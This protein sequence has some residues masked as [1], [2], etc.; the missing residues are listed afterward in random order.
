MQQLLEITFN[1]IFSLYQNTNILQI[2]I[3]K[4]KEYQK[5]LKIIDLCETAI[6]DKIENINDNDTAEKI[7]EIKTYCMLELQHKHC[8]ARMYKNIINEERNYE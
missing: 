1:Q 4:E 6:N 3:D 5:I 7:K 2:F 8:T